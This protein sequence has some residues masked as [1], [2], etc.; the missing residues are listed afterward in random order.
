MIQSLSGD[1]SIYMYIYIYKNI[2][3]H[4]TL[5]IISYSDYLVGGLIF[6]IVS[7]SNKRVD[8]GYK[9]IKL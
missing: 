2:Y 1:E 6:D 4:N 7:P 5:I 3:M 9:M 8:S